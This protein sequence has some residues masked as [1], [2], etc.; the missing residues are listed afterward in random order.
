VPSSFFIGAILLSS[1][2][3]G[4]GHLPVAYMLLSD[5]FGPALVLFVILANSA[6]GVVAGYLYWRRGLEA[7]I[8]AHMFCHVVL[9]SAS[10]AGAYF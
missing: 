10:A 9:A 1:L 3:F 7:A 8:I 4:A 6:F 2:V 5:S